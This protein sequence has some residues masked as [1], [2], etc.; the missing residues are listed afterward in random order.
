MIYLV[1]CNKIIPWH[2]LEHVCEQPKDNLVLGTCPTCKTTRAY[3]GRMIVGFEA[4]GEFYFCLACESYDNEAL[5]DCE[6][7][8]ASRRRWK[9]IKCDC[10][11]E[12]LAAGLERHNQP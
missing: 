1:C 3:K 7:V 10:C 4:L 11:G 12:T 5:V 9:T 6:P 2:E 8:F